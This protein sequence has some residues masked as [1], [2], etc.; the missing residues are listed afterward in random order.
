MARY[1]L[2]GVTMRQTT[3]TAL[4]VSAVLSLTVLLQAQA[5]FFQAAPIPI[6]GPSGQLALVDTNGDTHLDLVVQR[7]QRE[8]VVF[9]GNGR[10]QFSPAPGGPV[11]IFKVEPAATALGD[12]VADDQ[13]DLVVA[14]RDKDNEYLQVFRGDGHGRFGPGGTKRYR[15]NASFEYYKPAIKLA[16]VDANGSLD[17]ITSNGRRNTIEILLANGRSGLSAAFTAAPVVTL[18]PQS[19]FWTFGA[20]DIDGDGRLDL[21]TTFDPPGA[22]ST[23]VEIRKG[24][25][26]G[27][28]Q[29]P[30][31]GVDVR[32]GARIAAVADLNADRRPDVVLSHVDTGWMSILL[33]NGK[34]SLALA[35][36][37]PR[38]L[39]LQTFGVAVAD[40]N[41]DSRP[42]IVAATVNSRARPYESRLAVLLGDGFGGAAGS[43]L[44]VGNGAYQLAVGDVDED[45]RPDIVASSF[46]SES[47]SVLLGR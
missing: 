30:S 36:G 32:A 2:K 8:I 44:P 12:V 23:R 9:F 22:A 4:T 39:G 25:G 5:P 46:E 40:V 13:P 31:A 38:D 17:I 1:R 6:G 37:S 7:P 47:I 20:A 15:T 19:S 35:P 45:G 16:D 21:V 43:P 3:R 18:T 10:G 41:R 42:D 14:F 33:N 24:L 28:F 11:D 29:E 34:G 27:R 26:N